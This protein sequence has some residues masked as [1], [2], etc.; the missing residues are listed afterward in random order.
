MEGGQKL[1]NEGLSL[2][3]GDRVLGR[4]D[5]DAVLQG[6]GGQEAWRDTVG[7]PPPGTFHREGG[8]GGF[9]QAALLESSA[10]EVGDAFDGFESTPAQA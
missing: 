2:L 4:D 7:Q 3:E 8:G 9:I 1:G 5:Q 6:F 10:N